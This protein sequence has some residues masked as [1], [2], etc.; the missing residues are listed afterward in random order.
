M[1]LITAFFAGAFFCNSIPHLTNGL[2][3]TPFPTPFAKPPGVGDSSPVVN[4]L[5]GAFNFI[6]GVCLLSIHPLAVGWNA[7][8]IALFLG[9]LALGTPL[10]VRFGKVQK[11][12]LKKQP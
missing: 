3:G 2:Q 1:N 9:A 10:S 6:V 8:T 11:E 4:F 7:N 12:K 5:W